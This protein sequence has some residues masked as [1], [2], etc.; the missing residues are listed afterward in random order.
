MKKMLAIILMFT[1]FVSSAFSVT[2]NSANVPD[3]DLLITE[4]D[5]LI[6]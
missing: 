1:L 3:V 6:Y 4:I 2:V 5:E